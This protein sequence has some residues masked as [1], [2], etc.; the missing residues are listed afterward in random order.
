M[1]PTVAPVTGL[2]CV[3][4]TPPAPVAVCPTTSRA[5]SPASPLP[6]TCGAMTFRW[7]AASSGWSGVHSKDGG[8]RSRGLSRYGQPVPLS[9]LR[10]LRYTVTI[11]NPPPVTTLRRG[12]IRRRTYTAGP[13][14]RSPPRGLSRVRFGTGWTYISIYMGYPA[15]QSHLRAWQR[16]RRTTLLLL[17]YR[18][19]LG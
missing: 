2:L 17:I 9:L 12:A 19:T 11:G 3:P 1:I 4:W 10:Q 16:V 5:A 13:G 6:G 8:S 7:M 14:C 18:S 15:N